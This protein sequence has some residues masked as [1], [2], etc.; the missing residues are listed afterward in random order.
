MMLY[1]NIR[2]LDRTDRQFK[3]RCLYLDTKTLDPITQAAIEFVAQNE[4][5]RT[6]REI[7]KYR[8]LFI[9]EKSGTGP[10]NPDTWDSFRTVGPCEYFE[11]ETG[12]ELTLHEMGPILTGSPTGRLI[13]SGAKQ[14]DIDFMLAEPGPMPI[15]E[16]TLAPEDIRL[17]GYFVRDLQEMWDSAFMKDSPGSLEVAASIMISQSSEPT[18]ETAATDEEIRSFVTIFR[19]LYMSGHHDPASFGKIIPIFLKS[20]GDNPYAKWVDGVA[21]EYESYL[22]S[23]PDFR[24]FIQSGVCTFT[25]KR[26]IDVFLYTQYAHQPDEKRQRQFN[27]CLNEVHGKRVVLT[28]MFLTEIWKCSLKIGNAGR[29]ISRWFQHYCDHH[30]V[31]P[32]VLKS[33]RVD[34]LGLGA[35]EKQ[36]DRSSRLFREKT[37]ELAMEMWKQNNRPEGGPNQFLIMARERLAQ[38]CG[39]YQDR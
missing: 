26:L 8:H 24:P 3:N 7:L 35:A 9:D 4:S 36:K 18:L 25:T 6:E 28:W 31:S 15:A 10:G 34:H 37:E 2:Y 19:R 11:D 23:V 14:H 29:V 33:L 22:N 30:G 39:G 13:P 5:S 17:F 27:E 32:D 16:V 20:L 21:R 12:K 1:F 38:A